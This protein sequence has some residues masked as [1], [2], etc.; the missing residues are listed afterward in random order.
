MMW[1]AVD[2]NRSALK[3]TIL[4]LA[5]STSNAQVDAD[6]CGRPYP[7]VL[8]GGC[9]SAAAASSTVNDTT[10]RALNAIVPAT[11]EQVRIRSNRGRN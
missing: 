6:P 3:A 11:R 2:C 8:G 9:Q 4:I 1:H 10:T 7:A 5:S